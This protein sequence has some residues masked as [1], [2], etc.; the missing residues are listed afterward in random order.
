MAQSFTPW[1]HSNQYPA[2]D[3]P[4]RAAEVFGPQPVG[5]D[6]LD[7]LRMAWRSTP[8]ATIPDGYLGTVNSRRQD[9]LLDG[10]QARANNRPYTRGVHKG[11][12]IDTR[13][14]YWP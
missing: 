12:R 13:D 6:Y 3:A 1:Q 7:N 9:R 11:E 10:L 5:H 2:G 14:Y 8:E 4:F